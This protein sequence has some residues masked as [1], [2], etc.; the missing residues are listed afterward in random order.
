MGDNNITRPSTMALSACGMLKC[1]VGWSAVMQVVQ[2][3]RELNDLL[4]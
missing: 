1:T 3:A 2:V 4:E